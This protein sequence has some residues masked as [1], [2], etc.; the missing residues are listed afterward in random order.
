MPRLDPSAPLVL[1]VRELGRRA[2][3]MI[4]VQRTAPAPSDLGTVV[5]SVPEG[6]DI[7]LDL[8]LESV[9]EGVYVTG[10]ATVRAVGECSRCL[11]PM[12]SEDVVG[13]RSSTGTPTTITAAATTMM[14]YLSLRT[15]YL[16][17][18][19]HCATQ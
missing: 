6:T 18:S 19:P 10:T 14:N 13:C 7:E 2:G 16:T 17:L 5:I 11:D 4:T 12:V 1:D 15:I 8:Q 9:I 3:A